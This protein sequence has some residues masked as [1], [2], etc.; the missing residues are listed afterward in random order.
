M[1]EGLVWFKAGNYDLATTQLKLSNCLYSAMCILLAYKYIN[2]KDINV[3]GTITNK[4]MISL[5]DYSFGIFLAHAFV[6]LIMKHLPIYKYLVFP[7]NSA[8]VVF[9]TALCVWCGRK[10]LGVKYGKYLG[11]Y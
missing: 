5:G 9:I 11:L 2:N 6:I 7:I 1:A 10:I 4:I 8:L 3:K